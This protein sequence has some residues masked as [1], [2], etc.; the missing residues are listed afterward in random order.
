MFRVERTRDICY[1]F[2]DI[3]GRYFLLKIIPKGASFVG[4]K[5]LS[6]A[7]NYMSCTPTYVELPLITLKAPPILKGY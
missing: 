6:K 3:K 5:P 4:E 7:L 1:H 2:L